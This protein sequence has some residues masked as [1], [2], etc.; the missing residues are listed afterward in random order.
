MSFSG[1]AAAATAR[2]EELD[3]RAAAQAAEVIGS[4]SVGQRADL[5]SEYAREAEALQQ[6]D[7]GSRWNAF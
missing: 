2:L 7:M 4:N 6:L 1:A 3:A 5:S